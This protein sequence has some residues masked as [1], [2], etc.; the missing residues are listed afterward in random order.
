MSKDYLQTRFSSGNS[1]I[2]EE[3]EGI[4]T[5]ITERYIQTIIWYIN[6]RLTSDALGVYGAFSI[7]DLGKVPNDRYLLCT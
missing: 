6:D 1:Q 2:N 3:K 7:F 5:N 4:I